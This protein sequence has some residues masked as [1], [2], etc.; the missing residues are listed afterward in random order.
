[1]T[2]PKDSQRFKTIQDVYAA[3]PAI[4]CKGL[5]HG[6]CGPVPATHREIEAINAAS[7]IPFGTRADGY[8]AMLAAGRCSVYAQ[9]PLLC[10]LWG[11][12]EKMRCPHGCEPERWL[13]DAESKGLLAAAGRIGGGYDMERLLAMVGQV[14]KEMR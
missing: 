2:S 11:V 13:T 6:S 7:L 1:M 9:R 10:R 8:C 3:V 12:T 4:A 5:C 14:T